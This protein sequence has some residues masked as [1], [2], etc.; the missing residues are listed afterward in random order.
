MTLNG[1][2]LT[3]TGAVTID[4]LIELGVNDGTVNSGNVATVAAKGGSTPTVS[5]V[6]ASVWSRWA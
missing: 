3:V 2:T 6:P 1:G 5:F 4:N